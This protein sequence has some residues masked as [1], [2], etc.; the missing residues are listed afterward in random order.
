MN[1]RRVR[2]L[3]AYG[4]VL[5]TAVA[6]FPTVAA[7]GGRPLDATLVGIEEEPGPGDHDGSGTFAMTVN[8][9]QEEIC[10]TLE[11]A[12][13]DPARAAHIH[14]GEFGVAGPVV[15]PLAAPSDGSSEACTTVA[16]ELAL[17]IIRSP[18]EFYVN[19]HNQAFPGGA[20]RGQLG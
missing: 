20:I 9:G 16:R 7:A 5:A 17:E 6:S 13:I 15:V 8:P 11:V 18:E 19:V 14:R 4:V 2:Q 10:Y 12:D 1:V 3:A